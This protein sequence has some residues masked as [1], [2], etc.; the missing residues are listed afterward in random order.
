MNVNEQLY[1]HFEMNV[2]LQ[3]LELNCPLPL[4]GNIVV[5][6]VK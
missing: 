5:N 4:F 6:I 3:K 2:T 1:E